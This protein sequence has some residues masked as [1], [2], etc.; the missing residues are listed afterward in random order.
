MEGR[1]EEETGR[2]EEWWK[3]YVGIICRRERREICWWGG[4]QSLG[5]TRDLIWGRPKGSKAGNP[6]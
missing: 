4:R 3:S 1:I 5:V 6:S 2:G